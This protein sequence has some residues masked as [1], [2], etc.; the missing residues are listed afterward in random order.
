MVDLLTDLMI[1][2]ND[3]IV[4]NSENT[5]SMGGQRHPFVEGILGIELPVNRKGLSMDKYD[6]STYPNEHIDV[7]VTQMSLY[8]IDEAVLCRVLP[9]SLKRTTLS[10]FTCLPPLS[11]DCF[12]TLVGLFNTQFAINKPHHLMSLTLLNVRQDKGESRRAFMERFGGSWR[13]RYGVSALK[14]LFSKW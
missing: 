3:Q 5:L 7:Y 14:S 6:G 10:W 1:K 11:I 9:T 8:M 13:Y 12:E 4:D 2:F